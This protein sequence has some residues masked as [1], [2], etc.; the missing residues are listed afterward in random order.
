MSKGQDPWGYGR[1]LY[2]QFETGS[3]KSVL[4]IAA[5]RVGK[6]TPENSGATTTWYQQS[7]LISEA[8]KD[9]ESEDLFL[10]DLKEWYR[11]EK[12]Q[13]IPK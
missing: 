1:W 2:Q 10:T 6:R 8:N 5:Y 3:D 7:T 12:K 9:G 11:K 13:K 4:I